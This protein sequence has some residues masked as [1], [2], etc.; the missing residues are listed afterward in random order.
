M[1]KPYYR[2]V[3]FGM[4][5][6]YTRVVLET[7][8]SCIA[9]FYVTLWPLYLKN[10]TSCIASFYVTLWPLYLKNITITTCIASFYVTLWPLYLKKGFTTLKIKSHKFLMARAHQTWSTTSHWSNKTRPSKGRA[11]SVY[12]TSWLLY[13]NL[14]YFNSWFLCYFMAII[15]YSI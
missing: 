4:S 2:P 13:Y 12:V 8:T 15:Y 1:T 14:C 3:A 10:I 9:S 5:L 7:S 6:P 11:P